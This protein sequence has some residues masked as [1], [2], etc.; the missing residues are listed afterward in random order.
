M[1]WPVE[2]LAMLRRRVRIRGARKTTGGTEVDMLK[3]L[4]L[5]IEVNLSHNHAVQR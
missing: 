1:H 4:I 5:H 3:L 2:A